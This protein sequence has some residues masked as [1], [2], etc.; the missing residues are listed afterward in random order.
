MT[1]L[2]LWPPG[3]PPTKETEGEGSRTGNTR[4]PRRAAPSGP[5]SDVPGVLQVTVAHPDISSRIRWKRRLNGKSTV[6]FTF[7][8]HKTEASWDN[9]STSRVEVS[10]NQNPLQEHLLWAAGT[11]RAHGPGGTRHTQ[12]AYTARPPC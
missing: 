11:L 8:R 2:V 4:H 3:T 9:R 5:L 1:T 12:E 10:Q 6:P 7:P